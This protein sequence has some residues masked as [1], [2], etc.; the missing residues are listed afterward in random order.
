MDFDPDDA[1]ESV[2]RSMLCSVA[3]VASERSICV[4]PSL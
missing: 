2:V 4:Q 1:Y 3:I